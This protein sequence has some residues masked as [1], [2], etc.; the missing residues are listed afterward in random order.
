MAEEGR[1]EQIKKDLA[2]LELLKPRL[3]REVL[4]DGVAHP[5]PGPNTYRIAAYDECVRE[6]QMLKDVLSE[7]KE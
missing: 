5:R 4:E 6:I 1:T 3:E 7:R 2:D